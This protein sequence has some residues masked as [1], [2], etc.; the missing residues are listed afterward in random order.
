MEEFR[1]LKMLW[2]VDPLWEVKLYYYSNLTSVVG[3]TLHCA[4]EQYVLVRMRKW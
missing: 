2:T 3:H 1:L 4:D